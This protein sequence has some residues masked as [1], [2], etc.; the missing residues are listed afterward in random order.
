MKGFSLVELLVAM[1]A[2]SLLAVGSVFLTGY[3]MDARETIETRELRT[4]STSL[5]RPA[6]EPGPRTGASHRPPSRDGAFR[7]RGLSSRSCDAAQMVWLRTIDR[8]C[9]ASST[10]SRQA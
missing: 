3:A 9:R 8:T 5:R 4:P 2:L 10:A 7:V 1:A 6:G